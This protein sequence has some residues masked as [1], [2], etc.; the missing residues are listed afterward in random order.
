[1]RKGREKIIY[2]I[3]S[4][5]LKLFQHEISEEMLSFLKNLSWSFWG[6]LLAS[7]VMM[8]VNILGGRLLGPEEYGKYNLVL[9]FAQIIMIPMLFG[10]DIAGVRAV[11]MSKSIQGKAK[12]ISNAFYFIIFTSILIS[13]VVFLSREVITA[14]FNLEGPALL[15]A[16]FLAIILGFKTILDGF[17]RALSLFKYQFTTRI[18]EVSTITILFIVFFFVLKQ[19]TSYFYYIISIAGGAIVLILLYCKKVFPYFTKF[20]FK[21]LKKQISYGKILLVGTILGTV[22]NSLDKLVI[23]KYL[24]LSELGLYGAYYTAS[25][26]L[27]AQLSQ[28]FV[29]VFFPTLSKVKNKHAIVHKVNHIFKIGIVPGSLILALAIYII[30]QLFGSHYEISLFYIVG[31]AI[32]GTLQVVLTI[33]TTMITALSKRLFKKYI[34]YL[35]ILNVVYVGVYG[36]IIYL[37]FISLLSIVVLLITNVGIS[38]LIQQ[39]LI[40]FFLKKNSN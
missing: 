29:N 28:M 5:H 23:A 26:N 8:G 17:I 15:I 10:I 37:D 4:I 32:L 9:T 24:S 3:E 21:I 16:L 2:L 30:M 27:V 22:F 39:K 36:G 6:G 1:M 12:N 34:F 7:A 33:N 11:A 18:V 35:N 13:L 31:F 19:Q 40:H 38:I 20:D 14:R 25:T